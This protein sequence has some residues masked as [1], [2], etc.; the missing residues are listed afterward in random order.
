MKFGPLPVH[1]A[2]GAILAH[3]LAAPGLVLK[4]GTR[5]TAEHLR[6][7]DAAGVREVVTAVLEPGDVHEDEAAQ[8]IAEAA[9]GPGVH[10][11]RAFT[12]RSNLYAE[13]G[14]VLVVDRD[15]VQRVNRLDEAV[16]LA[17]R[18]PF[19]AVEPG[20]MIGTVKIIPFAV[21]GALVDEAAALLGGG[22]A[23][24]VAAFRPLRIGMVSTVLPGLGEKV[25]AKTVR[26]MEARL[27][28]MGAR[29]GEERR[30]PHEP[31]PLAAALRALRPSHDLL[32]V[33]GA[34]AI[35]DR[36][37]VIP[38]AIEAA[39]GRVGHFGMPVDPGN[40][41]LL[42]ELDGATVL[43]TPGCAR[44][45]KENGFDWVLQRLV[46]GLRVTDDD[47]AEMGVGGLLMEIVTRPQPREEKPRPA[48]LPKIAAVVL[49]AG[50]SRRMGGPNKLL[51]TLDGTPL[52]RRAAEAALASRA[53]PVIVVTG[54][55]AEAVSAALA[56]LDVRIVRN[57][58]YAEG[59]STSLRA[60]IAAVPEDADGAVVCLADMPGTTRDVIDRLLDAFSPEQGALIVVPTHEGKRGNPVLWSRRFF[61]ALK[62]VQG[63]VGARHLIGEHAEAVVELELGPAVTLDLDTPEAARA[64][65]VRLGPGDDARPPIASTVRRD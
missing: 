55:H 11:E 6:G 9:A 21:R 46:A 13:T 38:A 48:H 39:G 22:R 27:A 33:F 7:L 47:I 18:P 42:G 5:L 15:L 59:L 60:G 30:V 16:T 12:G 50:Q 20:R 34:S 28:A 40:L 52:V 56:G 32:V 8:R 19:A 58:D 49:A 26:T 37:D 41:L 4:K 65:G 24:R 1:E 2:E 25:L 63:D 44:S 35:T 64:A 29:L 45:P 62:S 31:E 3:S 53:A 61:D 51:A 57:P 23:L 17:T 43:G 54:H 36:R 10:V 14:G